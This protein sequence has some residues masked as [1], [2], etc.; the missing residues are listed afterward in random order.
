MVV[1]FWDYC[2]ICVYDLCQN[3]CVVLFLFVVVVSFFVRVDNVIGWCQWLYVSFWFVFVGNQVVGE[4]FGF[5]VQLLY[6][7]VLIVDQLFVVDLVVDS[8]IVGQDMVV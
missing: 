5:L 8:V 2:E 1:G 6:D 7:G 3:V 4:V